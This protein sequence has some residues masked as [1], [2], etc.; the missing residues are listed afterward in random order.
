MRTTNYLSF[1]QGTNDMEKI[2]AA[3]QWLVENPGSELVIE[4]GVY[5]TGRLIQSIPMIGPS[6]K[7]LKNS[8]R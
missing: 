5:N 8:N 2:A 6:I 3:M 4:P 7:W 1:F